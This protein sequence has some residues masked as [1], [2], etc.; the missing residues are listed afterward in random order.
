MS[1][2]MRILVAEEDRD[3][4]EMIKTSLLQTGDQYH[5]EAVSSGDDCLKKLTGEKYDILLLDHSLPDGNGLEWLR[6]F[7]QMGIGI[8]TVFVTAKGDPQMSIQAMQEGVFDYIN[9]SAECAK[10]FPFVVNRAIEGHNLMIEKV[11]LQKGADRGQ[12]FSRIHH[13]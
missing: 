3:F 2:I 13:R 11:R 7:N 1:R 9:R 8:P 6:R 10:A 12:E 5:V 4:I